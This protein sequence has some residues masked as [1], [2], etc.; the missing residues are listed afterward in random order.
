MFKWHFDDKNVAT[1]WLK[2]F[3]IFFESWFHTI[4]LWAWSTLHNRLNGQTLITLEKS[5]ASWLYVDKSMALNFSLFLKI[6]HVLGILLNSLKTKSN[7]IQQYK[8]IVFIWMIYLWFHAFYASFLFNISGCLQW[9]CQ[10]VSGSMQ[11]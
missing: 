3:H 10:G 5:R 11:C 9:Y 8:C 1:A 2:C 6:T 7:E 4:G